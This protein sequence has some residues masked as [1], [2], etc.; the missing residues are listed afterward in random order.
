MRKWLMA[1]AVIALAAAGAW[2]WQATAAT[3]TADTPATVAATR[4]TVERA[5][6]A[7]GVIEA[8]SLVAVGAR[9]LAAG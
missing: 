2:R 5:V 6:L 3:D 8:S 9:C 4:G 1:I 7:S